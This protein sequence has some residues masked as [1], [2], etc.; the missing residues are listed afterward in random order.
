[1]SVI[2]EDP[3]DEGPGEVRDLA[4][5]ADT[6]QSTLATKL[7]EGDSK[8]DEAEPVEAKVVTP[9]NASGGTLGPGEKRGDPLFVKQRR[10]TEGK[11]EGELVENRVDQMGNV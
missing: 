10:E 8:P 11:D 6:A 2:K 5:D 3:I 7:F 4:A 9:K 1:M